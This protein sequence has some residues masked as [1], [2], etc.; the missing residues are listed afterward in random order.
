MRTKDFLLAV[1]E[2]VLWYGFIVFALYSVKNPV[3]LYQ[4]ALILLVVGYLA[5]WAC[6][7]VRHSSGWRRTFN[8]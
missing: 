1:V 5:A 8:K 6:P 3:N 4:S 7:L 2:A